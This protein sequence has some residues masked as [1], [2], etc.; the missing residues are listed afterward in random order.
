M[1][2]L[3]FGVCFDCCWVRSWKPARR[4][5]QFRSGS[6]TGFRIDKV[7]TINGAIAQQGEHCPRMADVRGSNPRGSIKRKER[8][9]SSVQ[10]VAA[11]QC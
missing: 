4:G 10:T 6:D 5:S 3:L 1:F 11:T 7:E 2:F 9:T 8:R